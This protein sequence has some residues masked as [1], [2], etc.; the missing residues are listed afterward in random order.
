[1]ICPSCKTDLYVIDSRNERKFTNLQ[2]SARKQNTDYQIKKRWLGCINCHNR[3]FSTEVLNPT[4]YKNKPI[5]KS[6]L[7]N[8]MG[9][10]G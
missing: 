3:Y 8:I 5:P 7:K 4:P 10:E 1:M 6:R 2:A 9:M